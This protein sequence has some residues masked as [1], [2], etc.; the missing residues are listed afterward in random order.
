QGSGECRRANRNGAAA[1]P[2]RG[3][4]HSLALLR[5]VCVAVYRGTPGFS[6]FAHEHHC[7]LTSGRAPPAPALAPLVPSRDSPSPRHAPDRV[8][9]ACRLGCSGIQA[10]ST[11][12]APRSPLLVT[13]TSRNPEECG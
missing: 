8:A 12:S 4:L 2:R 11:R 13:A 1:R 7:A 6:C 10:D 3:G 9:S 5:L